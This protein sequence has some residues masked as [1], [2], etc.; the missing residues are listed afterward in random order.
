MFKF[1]QIINFLEII[2]LSFICYITITYHNFF[3]QEENNNYV[4]FSSSNNLNDND[5]DEI[6]YLKQQRKIYI[7]LLKDKNLDFMKNDLLIKINNIDE[8]LIILNANMNDLDI[9][10]F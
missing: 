7:D 5:Y 4:S 1:Q 2:F 3:E 6:Y 8:R 9:I 10:I